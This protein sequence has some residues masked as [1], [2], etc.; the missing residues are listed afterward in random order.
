M[1][2]IGNCLGPLPKKKSECIKVCRIGEGSIFAHPPKLTMT[3]PPNI[4]NTIL[5]MK[6]AMSGDCTTESTVLV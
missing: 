5:P 3:P 6:C 4:Q 1:A 2:P